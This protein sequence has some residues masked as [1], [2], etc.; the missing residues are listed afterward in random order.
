MA[1]SLSVGTAVGSLVDVPAEPDSIAYG[2]MDIS[3]PDA[4]RVQDQGNTMYKDRISQKRKLQLSWTD[5]ALADASAILRM[6]NPEYVYVRYL[7]VL[8]GEFETRQFY[9]G[10]RT[11]PFRQI[12]VADATGRRTVMATLSFDII[13]R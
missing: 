11:S 2:L 5:I 4:G 9:V 1:S 3:A 13:E 7:D 6:F 12:S 8:D 10:D